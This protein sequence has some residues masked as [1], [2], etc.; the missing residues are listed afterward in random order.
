MQTPPVHQKHLNLG[1]DATIDLNALPTQ[2]CLLVRFQELAFFPVQVP[3]VGHGSCMDHKRENTMLRQMIY[4]HGHGRGMINVHCCCFIFGLCQL[5]HLPCIALGCAC[6][7]SRR[8][9]KTVCIGIKSCLEG[10]T[11]GTSRL[12]ICEAVHRGLPAVESRSSP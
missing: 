9:R 5:H 4:S 12:I 8:L 1:W 11:S 6:S 7:T 10:S 2:A 3:R